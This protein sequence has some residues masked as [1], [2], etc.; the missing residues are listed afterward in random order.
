M[1]YAPLLQGLLWRSYIYWASTGELFRCYTG[2][3]AHHW[4]EFIPLS[5]GLLRPRSI[6]RSIKHCAVTKHCAVN[7]RRRKEGRRKIQILYIY[8]FFS[9]LWSRAWR[10]RPSKWWST[11]AG[12]SRQA[13]WASCQRS[14]SSS[15]STTENIYINIYTRNYATSSILIMAPNRYKYPSI[16]GV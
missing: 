8:Y 7:L 6:E 4:M 11:S 2:L 14:G 16:A 10:P 5:Q 13:D 9:T 15:N 1:E 3:P 12:R